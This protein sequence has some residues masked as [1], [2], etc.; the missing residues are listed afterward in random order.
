MDINKPVKH[1]NHSKLIEAAWERKADELD[2]RQCVFTSDRLRI[3]KIP[4]FRLCSKC[5]A[6]LR[7]ETDKCDICGE[8]QK[9]SFAEAYIRVSK[10][11]RK[12]SGFLFEELK[13]QLQKEDKMVRGHSK[14]KTELEATPMTN[15]EYHNYKDSACIAGDG[16]EGYLVLKGSQEFWIEKYAFEKIFSIGDSV[17]GICENCKESYKDHP[18]FV[19]KSEKDEG[20]W[21]C[22]PKAEDILEELKQ[23]AMAT[24]NARVREYLMV[25]SR[26]TSATADSLFKSSIEETLRIYKDKLIKKEN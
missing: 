14:Y 10:K 2:A 16:V 5:K 9:E 21:K 20:Y 13:K 3:G 22:G 1:L 23:Y 11:H 8:I 12:P 4:P 18:H 17:L 7:N 15:H 19:A 6:T 25:D 24:H 26:I